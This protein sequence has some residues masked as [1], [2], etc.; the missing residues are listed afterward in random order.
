MLAYWHRVQ[1]V[2]AGYVLCPLAA[3]LLLYLEPAEVYCACEKILERDTDLLRD[4]KE[5]SF[6]WHVASS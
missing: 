6:L 5:K 1:N 3:M 4:Q 2:T